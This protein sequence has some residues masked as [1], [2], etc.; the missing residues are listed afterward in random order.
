MPYP[1]FGMPS[2][3]FEPHHSSSKAT[4]SLRCFILHL[5]T[6]TALEPISQWSKGD[7]EMHNRNRTK[8]PKGSIQF[9][10]DERNKRYLLFPRFLMQRSTKANTSTQRKSSSPFFV[11]N[12]SFESHHN[13]SEA[14]RGLR[15]FCL[16][17]NTSLTGKVTGTRLSLFPFLCSALDS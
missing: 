1:P 17:G 4:S 8:A 7:S 10:E 5:C 13:S 9:A 3:Y 14:T 2:I 15:R 6:A 16:W 11:P 12:I